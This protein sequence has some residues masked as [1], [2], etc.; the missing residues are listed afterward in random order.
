MGTAVEQSS[1]ETITDT[2]PPVHGPTQEPNQQLADSIPVKV[3]YRATQPNS[4]DFVKKGKRKPKCLYVSGYDNSVPANAILQFVSDKGVS[5]ASVSIFPTRRS[6]R[7]VIVRLCVRNDEYAAYPLQEGF[8]PRVIVCKLW[9][10][11]DKMRHNNRLAQRSEYSL[12]PRFRN[13]NSSADLSTTNSTMTV[14]NR[15][16]DYR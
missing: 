14:T 5:V 13:I 10:S 8:W 11:R 4:N 3:T 12:S 16:T 9:Q 2:V 6:P 1:A 15:L 7:K